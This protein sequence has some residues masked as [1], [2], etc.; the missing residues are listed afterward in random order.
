MKKLLYF[1]VISVLA[2]A[3]AIEA[4]TIA[5]TVK[6]N[7]EVPIPTV[8][9][10]VDANGAVDV[11]N[12]AGVISAVKGTVTGTVDGNAT[13][14]IDVGGS[15]DADLPRTGIE[16]EVGTD[17]NAQVEGSDDG[18]EGAEDSTEMEVSEGI[19]VRAVEVRGW[20]P[21]K[22][23]EVLGSA[24]MRTEVESEADLSNF[25]ATLVI[26]DENI[27]SVNVEDD[28]VEM[29]YNFPAKFLGIFKTNVR[30][31]V[32]VATNATAEDRVKVKFSWLSFL[33]TMDSN[34]KAA[35]L[36]EAIDAQ[37]ASQVMVEGATNASVEA[38]VL[39]TIGAVLRVKH[40]MSVNA[41]A[42]AAVSAET[43]VE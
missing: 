29:S 33:Y 4:A 39:E 6:A 35:A 11:K 1:S 38:G 40:D 5:N 27:N 7:V 14:D 32:S 31:R 12:E 22:K 10:D 28:G 30:A 2:F 36:T 19:S 34:V 20:N 8:A 43:N 9:A 41:S 13:A 26:N 25:A 3:G 16:V 15:V 42:E 37:L 24:L 23:A 18:A 21:E 17:V